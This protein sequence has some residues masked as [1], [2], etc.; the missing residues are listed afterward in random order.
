MKIKNLQNGR[1]IDKTVHAGDKFQVPELEYKKMQYL[2]DDGD[3]LQFM[4][5]ETFDQ[6]GLTVEQ[7]GKENFD[8][9]VDGMEV[10]V[11]F[12]KGKPN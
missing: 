12:H 5:S 2:Y 8:Y 10:T 9:M 7:V 3:F 6:L 4:D 1:V 11:L